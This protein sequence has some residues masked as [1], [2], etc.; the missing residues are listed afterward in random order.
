MPH[1]PGQC[2][3]R[4]GGHEVASRRTAP[5]DWKDDPQCWLTAWLDM[6]TSTMGSLPSA[7]CTLC[8]A[9]PSSGCMPGCCLAS[10]YLG[11]R[12]CPG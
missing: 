8:L 7:L 12:R 9:V 4:F 11:T 10:K 1:S 2:D 6:A 3:D 5:T